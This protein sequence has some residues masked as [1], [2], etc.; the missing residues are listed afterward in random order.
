[1]A[2]SRKSGSLS[3]HPLPKDHQKK[4]QSWSSDTIIVNGQSFAIIFPEK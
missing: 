1:M 4:T 2:Q 3:A